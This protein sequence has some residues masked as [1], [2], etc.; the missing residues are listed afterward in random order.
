MRRRFVLLDRDGTL[1]FE[2]HYLSS[3]QQVELLPGAAAG[4]RV[5]RNLGL[6]LVVLTNQSGVGRGLFDLHALDRIHDRLNGLLGDKGVELD[7]IYFCPHL[8]DDACDCR[9]PATGMALHAATDLGF[10]TAQ[11][12]V[13]GD[14]AIDM[15]LGRAIGATT[16]LV[17][18]GYGKQEQQASA[19]HA[20]YVTEDL[21]G[22]AGIIS[23]L[24]SPGVRG[25]RPA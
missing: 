7:R 20:D 6:G 12:F 25:E 8:P 2:R 1:I 14:K 18:T 22:A 15:K 24:V 11:A 4:L 9:K 13:I 3:P 21:L 10:D 17:L 16:L 23:S 5:L 19:G